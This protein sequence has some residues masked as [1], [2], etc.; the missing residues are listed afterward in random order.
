MRH[1]KTFDEAPLSSHSQILANVL[2]TTISKLSYSNMR[3][4]KHRFYTISRLKTLSL[5]LSTIWVTTLI[6]TDKISLSS[7]CI[8]D[9]GCSQSSGSVIKVSNTT[10]SHFIN[11]LAHAKPYNV[12]IYQLSPIAQILNMLLFY[13]G[14]MSL[15][16]VSLPYSENFDCTWTSNP[17]IILLQSINSLQNKCNSDP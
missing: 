8:W 9:R 2:R 17:Q 12:Q 6:R 1:L 4:K 5:A 7:H 13:G 16:I 3:C 14:L 15:V 11:I 10:L